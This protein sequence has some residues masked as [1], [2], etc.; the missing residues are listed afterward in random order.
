MPLRGI[1]LP[2]SPRNRVPG[3][4]ARTVATKTENVTIHQLGIVFWHQSGD[5]LTNRVRI[6]DEK[7]LGSGL[8]F[9]VA[10]SIILFGPFCNMNMHHQITPASARL[11]WIRN[12][13][14]PTRFQKSPG[15]LSLG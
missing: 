13:S 14:S 7:R 3:C 4:L 8:L 10:D 2:N 12:L 6:V 9:L 1:G 11:K 15:S 5:D